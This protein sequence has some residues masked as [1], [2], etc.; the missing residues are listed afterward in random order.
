MTSC[1]TVN[2]GTELGRLTLSVH[3]FSSIF[4][5]QDGLDTISRADNPLLHPSSVMALWPFWGTTIV[6]N[7]PVN[8]ILLQLAYRIPDFSM[9]SKG[10]HILGAVL[11]QAAE[12]RETLYVI[13]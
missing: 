11:F 1:A 6:L 8:L 12:K 7:F 3:P 13:K 2:R 10:S 4:K 5:Q 9:E